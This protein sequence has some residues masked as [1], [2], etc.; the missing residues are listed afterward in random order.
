[1]TQFSTYLICRASRIVSRDLE[2]NPVLRQQASAL[3]NSVVWRSLPPAIY[4]S[5]VCPAPVLK[6][7]PFTVFL[8]RPRV[9]T[10][11]SSGH[12]YRSSESNQWRTPRRSRSNSVLHAEGPE[13]ACR[14][15][16]MAKPQSTSFKSKFAKLLVTRDTTHSIL[17]LIVGHNFSADKAMVKQRRAALRQMKTHVCRAALSISIRSDWLTTEVVLYYVRNSATGCSHVI[18]LIIG[19]ES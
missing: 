10:C 12:R 8:C 7:S 17:S 2:D 9:Q 18:Y 3:R 11:A 16:Q 15:T 1:M 19:E 4:S 6:R 14:L 5:C 13:R